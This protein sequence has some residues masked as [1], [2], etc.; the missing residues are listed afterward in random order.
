MASMLDCIAD[1][2]QFAKLTQLTTAIEDLQS[3]ITDTTN[4]IIKYTSHGESGMRG[5]ISSVIMSHS[6]SVAN[7]TRAVLSSSN[8]DQVDELTRRFEV[9][10]QQFDRGV[11][12]QSAM[13]LEA[14]LEV[15]SELSLLFM[16]F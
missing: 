12:I 14:A 13:T 6:P 1:V 7:T 15:L 2:G 10:K 9:F 5:L 3:I 16:V 4:F 8:P 11:S